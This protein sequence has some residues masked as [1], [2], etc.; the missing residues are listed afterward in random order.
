MT[1]PTPATLDQ[2]RDAVAAIRALHRPTAG[3]GYRASGSYGEI[4]PVCT[5]CGTPDEDGIP[6]PCPTICALAAAGVTQ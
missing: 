5:T 2:Y 4:D 6:W 1:S 3:L